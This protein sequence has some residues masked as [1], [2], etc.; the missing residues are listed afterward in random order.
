M[1]KD[2]PL[3]FI[4]LLILIGPT[5]LIAI[6]LRRPS[7]DPRAAAQHLDQDRGGS[8]HS[9]LN[10]ILMP[11]TCAFDFAFAKVPSQA[12]SRVTGGLYDISRTTDW[13]E[14]PLRTMAKAGLQRIGPP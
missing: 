12:L 13:E 6:S 11:L 3:S 8:D 4:L 14:V 9:I 10:E 2:S 5:P 1:S 7:S